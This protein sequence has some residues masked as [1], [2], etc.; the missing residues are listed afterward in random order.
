MSFSLS[1]KNQTQ[2]IPAL[3]GPKPNPSTKHQP[4]LENIHPGSTQKDGD[5]TSKIDNS[6]IDKAAQKKI[7]SYNS[8]ITLW[9]L[10]IPEITKD[11]VGGVGTSL[12]YVFIYI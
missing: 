11:G 3:K 6:V 1:S 4:K 12:S 7:E 5:T 8:S 9:K 10:D 2:S